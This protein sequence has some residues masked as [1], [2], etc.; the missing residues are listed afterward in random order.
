MVYD[1]SS[2]TRFFVLRAFP[3]SRHR[4]VYDE[5]IIEVQGTANV[6]G[7][8]VYTSSLDYA[9]VRR[10]CGILLYTACVFYGL[11]YSLIYETSRGY[12]GT[13]SRTRR[14]SR[15]RSGVT[16]VPASVAYSYFHGSGVF[17]RKAIL[18]HRGRYRSFNGAYQVASFVS[19]LTMRGDSTIYVRRC[20]YLEYSLEAY[21]PT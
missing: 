2:P 16:K 5:V 9:F 11:N 12:V 17:F 14:F 21:E 3:R 18:R 13:Y 7:V 6:C 20:P 10:V 8:Y 1:T 19:T 4:I 15:L